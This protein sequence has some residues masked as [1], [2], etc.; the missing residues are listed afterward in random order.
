MQMLKKKE[1]RNRKE[2]D[3]VNKEEENKEEA[4][5]TREDVEV[6]VITIQ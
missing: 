6:V 1:E 4:E 3:D 2:L 5:I